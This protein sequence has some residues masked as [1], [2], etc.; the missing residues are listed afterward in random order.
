MVMEII[1]SVILLIVG[2]AILIIIHICVVGRAFRGHPINSNPVRAAI[3]PGLSPEDI[4]ALPCLDYRLNEENG[5]GND[6]N[7]VECAVCLEGYKSGE[8]CRVL[9]KCNHIFH[10]ECIDSWLL[11]TGAC[12]IC[13]ATAKTTQ[14]GQDCSSFSGEAGL[15]LV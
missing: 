10:C 8:K 1:V 7:I 2:I 13:R 3:I 4:K 14:F 6:G 9:P 15:E 5:L 11:K 12:P